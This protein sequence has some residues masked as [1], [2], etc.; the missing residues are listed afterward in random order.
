MDFKT[1]KISFCDQQADNVMTA[2]SK[3]FIL[4]IVNKYDITINKIPWVLN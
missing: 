3:K 4:D 2:D 1:Q